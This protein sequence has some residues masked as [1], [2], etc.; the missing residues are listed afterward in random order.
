MR[1]LHLYD[2][3]TEG[4]ATFVKKNSNHQTCYIQDLLLRTINK[5]NCRPADIK[6]LIRLPRALL[7][8]SLSIND[9]EPPIR[10]I[11]FKMLNPE[12]WG[13]FH[14]HQKDI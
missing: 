11:P 9:R 12:I 4:I 1:K 6:A 13:A 14:E 5:A 10:K 7:K 2:L 3:E 8:F